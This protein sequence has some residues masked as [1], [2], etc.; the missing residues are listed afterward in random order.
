MFKG[1][2][3]LAGGVYSGGRSMGWFIHCGLC[4]MVHVVIHLI[5]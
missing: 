5:Q 3:G 1:G 4:V 2:G